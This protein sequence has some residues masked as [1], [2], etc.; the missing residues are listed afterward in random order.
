MSSTNNKNTKNRTDHINELFAALPMV[1]GFPL[2]EAE[3]RE[4]FEKAVKDPKIP[5][6]KLSE[7]KEK[8]DAPKRASGHNIFVK[9]YKGEDPNV[10][11][12]MADKNVIWSAYSDEEKAVWNQKA[13]EENT[14][15]GFK[16]IEKKESLASRQDKWR[17]EWQRWLQADESTRGPEPEMPTRA[18]P[19]PKPTKIEPDIQVIGDIP[20][21]A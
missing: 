13:L 19:T 16:Q 2:T 20:V 10:K 5:I 4:F 14:L 3:L 11:L 15:N 9:T 6:R 1:E 21:T 17:E 12:S 18:K 7:K 8:S